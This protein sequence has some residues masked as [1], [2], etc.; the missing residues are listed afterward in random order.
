MSIEKISHSVISAYTAIRDGVVNGY[1]KVQN[2]AVGG[3]KKVEDGCIKTLFAK[4]DETV[5]EAK[6]RLSGKQEGK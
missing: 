3:Y 5:E 4:Q 1:F 2:A 6:A